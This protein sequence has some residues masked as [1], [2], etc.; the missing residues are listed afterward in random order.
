M[1]ALISH[2]SMREKG[3]ILFIF[4]QM[5]PIRYSG[6]LS[7][8]GSVASEYFLN[9]AFLFS[10]APETDTHADAIPF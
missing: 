8:L 3:S 6:E 10:Q 9:M 4:S 5:S 2:T 7:C 1:L